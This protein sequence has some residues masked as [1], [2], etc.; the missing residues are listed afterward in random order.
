MTHDQLIEI[1][2]ARASDWERQGDGVNLS[3]MPKV[4]VRD[5]VVVR[6]ESGHGTPYVEI[7]LDRETGQFIRGTHIPPQK[8]EK[9]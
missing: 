7:V 5:A 9:K 6:F 1:A 2:R 3:D 8:G 4:S